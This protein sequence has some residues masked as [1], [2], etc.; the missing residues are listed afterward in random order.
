M[1]Q[2]SPWLVATC[3]HAVP[4]GKELRA[5][6]LGNVGPV[7]RTGPHRTAAGPARQAGP[8]FAAGLQLSELSQGIP[9]PR[10]RL[11]LRFSLPA[12]RGQKQ[13]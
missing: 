13:E 10:R 2:S 9:L 5:N 1:W 4:C 3:W 12:L 7:C 6:P 11:F 8:T